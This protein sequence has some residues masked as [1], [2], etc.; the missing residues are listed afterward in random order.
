M[1]LRRCRDAA[2]RDGSFEAADGRGFLKAGGIAMAN[3][4]VL[5]VGS[6][7]GGSISAARLAAAGARVVVLERGP[8]RDTVPVRSMGIEERSPLPQG[9]HMLSHLVRTIRGPWLRPDGWTLNSHGFFDA[10]LG[11]GLNV[12]CSSSVG[13]GS[14]AYAGLNVRPAIEGYWDGHADDLSDELMEPH[15]RGVLESMGSRA[16]RPADAVPNTTAERFGDSPV[17]QGGW[18]TVD[19]PRGFLFPRTPGMPRPVETVDGITRHESDM[20]D[21]G[22]F[23]SA[24]GAKTTLDFAVL[25]RA[26]RKG[27][28]V[29]P[30]VEAKTIARQERGSG[31]RYRI[32]AQN[33]QTGRSEAFQ[34]ESVFVAAGTLNTVRLL[35]AS[36]AAGGLEGMPALGRR[37]GGNGDFLAYWNLDDRSRDLTRGLVAHGVLRMRTPHP[38]GRGRAWPMT[39]D[40]ALPSPDGCKL[41]RW[42]QRKMR[43]GS[44]IAAMGIDEQD[45]EVRWERGRMRI[46]YDPAGSRIFADICDALAEISRA[47][48]R[49]IWHFQRPLTVH[50]TG[51]ACLGRTAEEAVVDSSGRVFGHDGLHVADAAALPRPVGAPPSMTIAAWAEHVAD[52]FVAES[53]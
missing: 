26:M 38:L 16:P 32:E 8:W 46:E 5:V 44:I 22:L 6:G 50:P 35:L 4:D 42:V 52:R 51:G 9:P 19:I 2:S 23:G 40:V 13:G 49:R 3:A 29:E 15:Y 53:R 24:S 30:L 39:V 47:T 31:A 33:H 18:D 21:G 1:P 43:H 14:H 45:G 28:R 41:P 34:A 12:L 48:G 11:K 10:W 36:R 20:H 27:L 17:L 7:F 37:F 25:G